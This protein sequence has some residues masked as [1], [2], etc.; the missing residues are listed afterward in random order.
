MPRT[1]FLR[2]FACTKGVQWHEDGCLFFP[3]Y[4]MDI[5]PPTFGTGKWFN[6]RIE[7]AKI[8]NYRPVGHSARGFFPAPRKPLQIERLP[9]Y[10]FDARFSHCVCC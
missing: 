6:P 7:I 9:L 1:E 8:I 5:V 10:C 3:V 2:S 4:Q